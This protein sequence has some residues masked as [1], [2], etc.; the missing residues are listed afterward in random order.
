MSSALALVFF[1]TL[2]SRCDLAAARGDAQLGPEVGRSRALWQRVVLEGRE[3]Q[4]IGHR[5][6]NAGHCHEDEEGQTHRAS[7]P[8]PRNEERGHCNALRVSRLQWRGAA[9]QT[10]LWE[11]RSQGMFDFENMQLQNAIAH[12]HHLLCSHYEASIPDRRAVAAFVKKYRML[13]PAMQTGTP[14]ACYSC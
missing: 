3:H 6:Q 10:G 7:E 9:R 12:A 8:N 11:S 2:V 13:T 1:T 4:Q 14:G 5:S